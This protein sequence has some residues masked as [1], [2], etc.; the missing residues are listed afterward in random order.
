MQ[1]PEQKEGLFSLRLFV[2]FF[3]HFVQILLNFFGHLVDCL[4]VWNKTKWSIARV[5]FLSYIR[6]LHQKNGVEFRQGS[7]VVIRSGLATLYEV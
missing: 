1:L 7:F 6:L 4:V 5:Q 2:L 3:C